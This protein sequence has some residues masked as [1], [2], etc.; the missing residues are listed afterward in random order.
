MKKKNVTD[1]N[2]YIPLI[3]A[4]ASGDCESVNLLIEK[5]VPLDQKNHKSARAVSASSCKGFGNILA[6]LIKAGARIVVQY[7]D[8]YDMLLLATRYG[9]LQAVELL[10]NDP[11]ILAAGSGDYDTVQ[12]LIENKIPLNHKTINGESTLL[13]AA[14]NGHTHVLKLLLQSGVLPGNI[15]ED[16]ND[17]IL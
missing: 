7:L 16:G 4:A 8:G 10:V 1:T 12:L 3:A 6:S 2:G 15:D 14:K 17:V 13:Q 11:L 5:K 9:D